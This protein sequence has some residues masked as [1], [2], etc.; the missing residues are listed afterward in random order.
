MQMVCSR[1]DLPSVANTFHRLE[2]NDSLPNQEDTVF[3]CGYVGKGI[4]VGLFLAALLVFPVKGNGEESNATT[5]EKNSEFHKTTDEDS[6]LTMSDVM[7]WVQRFGNRVG[8]NISEATSKT[9]SA[10][11]NATSDNIQEPQSKDSP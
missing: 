5:S 7:N 10:I 2:H 3:D 8:E 4:I 1:S 6:G 9:A 11:K